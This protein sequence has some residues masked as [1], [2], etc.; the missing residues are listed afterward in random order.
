[1]ATFCVSNAG[2]YGRRAT[3]QACSQQRNP[4]LI[5]VE[6]RAGHGAGKPTAKIIQETAD[7]L[8]YAA[9]VMGAKWQYTA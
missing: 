3:G 4:L 6:V 5:R 9:E 2:M 8:S 1:M 7:M